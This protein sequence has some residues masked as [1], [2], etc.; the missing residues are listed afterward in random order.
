[1][2]EYQHRQHEIFSIHK[3]SKRLSSL[4]CAYISVAYVGSSFSCTRAGRPSTCR[5]RRKS[6]KIGPDS[7]KGNMMSKWR[8]CVK[9]S[10]STRLHKVVHI[11]LRDSATC[12]QVLP[13]SRET[14]PKLISTYPRREFPNPASANP[15]GPR[16]FSAALARVEWTSIKYD[17]GIAK[18]I[19]KIEIAC[20]SEP[21]HDR[22]SVAHADAV[23]VNQQKTAAIKSLSMFRSTDL[24]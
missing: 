16:A 23:A 24:Q 17:C 8:R 9:F 11:N 4:T 10:Q 3:A 14:C 15:T 1:M 22:W 2:I 21:S 6:I 20:M 13:T 5:P 12:L 18:T 7:Q 19:R